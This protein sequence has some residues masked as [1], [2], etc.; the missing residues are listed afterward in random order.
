MATITLSHTYVATTTKLSRCSTEGA[1]IVHHRC[2]FY[3]DLI[4]VLLLKH[5]LDQ[6]Y[7]YYYYNYY[8]DGIPTTGLTLPHCYKYQSDKGWD[9]EGRSYSWRL[10]EMP[11]PWGLMKPQASNLMFTPN[12]RFSLYCELSNVWENILLN[13]RKLIYW[14]LLGKFFLVWKSLPKIQFLYLNLAVPPMFWEHIRG[15]PMMYF[16]ILVAAPSITELSFDCSLPS[17][18]VIGVRW[19]STDRTWTGTFAPNTTKLGLSSNNALCV[20]LKESH[21]MY[22]GSLTAQKKCPVS[23]EISPTY[24]CEIYRL[25]EIGMRSTNRTAFKL[26]TIKPCLANLAKWM[27]SLLTDPVM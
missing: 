26:Y 18:H 15:V 6:S 20:Q 8:I 23:D 24:L 25:C 13:Q 10:P 17:K 1:T 4:T 5:C 11:L 3:P 12:F 7:Y 16:T 9:R 19:G 27:F 21:N 2:R 22:F 14:T